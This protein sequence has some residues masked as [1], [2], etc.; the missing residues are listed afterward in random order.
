MVVVVPRPENESD[1]EAEETVVEPDN[2]LGGSLFG[3][4]E[5]SAAVVPADKPIAM[6][7]ASN[8]FGFFTI[9]IRN[10]TNI[11]SPLVVVD[12]KFR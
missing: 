1:T 10:F 8:A 4:S 9:G 2:G 7:H 11:Q 5:Y 12:G 6:L 3:I